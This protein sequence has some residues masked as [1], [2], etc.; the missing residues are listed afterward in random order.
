MRGHAVVLDAT[1][2]QTNLTSCQR[3]PEIRQQ[4]RVEREETGR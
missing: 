4:Q 3:P 2:E 1:I